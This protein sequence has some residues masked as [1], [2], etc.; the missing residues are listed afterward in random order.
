MCL[1]LVLLVRHAAK[2]KASAIGIGG[3]IVATIAFGAA[4][5]G[6]VHRTSSEPQ[7]AA[8]AGRWAAGSPWSAT[9]AAG[10]G[11]DSEGWPSAAA[12]QPSLAG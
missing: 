5:V 12:S 2:K 7:A 1:G 9:G 4:A 10:P 8:S 3:A 11:T 6:L